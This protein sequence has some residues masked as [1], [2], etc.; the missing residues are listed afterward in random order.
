MATMPT[1]ATKLCRV[2]QIE[3][4]GFTNDGYHEW[5]RH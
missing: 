2:N 1:M 4:G 3:R 5:T